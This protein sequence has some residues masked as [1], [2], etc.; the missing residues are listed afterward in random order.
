MLF[1][2]RASEIVLTALKSEMNSHYFV[3]MKKVG[4]LVPKLDLR[5]LKQYLQTNKFK[6]LTNLFKCCHLGELVFLTDS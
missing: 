5:I 6:M 3:A 4:G 1:A 2:K